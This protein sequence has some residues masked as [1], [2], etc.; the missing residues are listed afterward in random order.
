MAAIQINQ[1]LLDF[2]PITHLLTFPVK[3]EEQSVSG[4]GASGIIIEN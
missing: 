2:L 1:Y 3:R 4:G